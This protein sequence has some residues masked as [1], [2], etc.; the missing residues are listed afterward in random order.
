MPH[1][2][3]NIGKARFEMFVDAILAIIMT[4]MVLD[5]KVPELED[6]SNQTLRHEI[7][8][9]IPSFIGF[10][11]SFFTVVIIW[12]DHHDLLKSIQGITKRF[13]M[14]N[15]ILIAVIGTLPYSTALAWRYPQNGQAVVVYAV[16]ILLLNASIALV[17]FYAIGTNLV[18]ANFKQ[19]QYMSVKKFVSIGGLVVM[20]IAVSISFIQPVASLVCAGLVPL[21]HAIMMMFA[22]RFKS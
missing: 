12:I 16:N 10:L 21:S 15:F 1:S 19:S 20:V 2:Y 22:A 5:I 4:I 8:K 13:A 7:V 11:I 6:V 9:A 14:L 18:D 17:F 3:L